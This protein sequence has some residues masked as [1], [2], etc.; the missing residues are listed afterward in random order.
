MELWRGRREGEGGG[1]LLEFIINLPR[2]MCMRGMGH[3][4]VSPAYPNDEQGGGAFGLLSIGQ[5]NCDLTC[6]STSHCDIQKSRRKY[7]QS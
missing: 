4:A 5:Q 7:W 3:D 1:S 2:V 6:L